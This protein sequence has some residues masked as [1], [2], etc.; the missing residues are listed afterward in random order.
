MSSNIYSKLG[1]CTKFFKRQFFRAV[2]G[3]QQNWERYTYIPYCVCL[4]HPANAQPPSLSASPTRMVHLLQLRKLPWHIIITLSLYFILQFT[5]GVVHSMCLNK[6]IMTCIYH[7]RISQ[8]IF[9][10]IKSSVLHI[11]PVT[12]SNQWSFYCF[13]SF[14]ISR[15][16]Y[17]WNYTVCSLFRLAS[18]T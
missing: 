3:S 7:Y 9:T 13:H 8:S 12:S 4:P 16:S 6:C 2:L 17:S 15:M 14:A 5:L 1:H 10:A 18:F 11:F